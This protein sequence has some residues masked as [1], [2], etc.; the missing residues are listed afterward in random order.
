MPAPNKD[1]RWRQPTPMMQLVALIGS[2]EGHKSNHEEGIVTDTQYI[3]Y[4]D[5]HIG[6]LF[7]LRP[8]V[9]QGRW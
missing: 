6:Q 7:N 9:E 5:D 1:P 4:C 3:R 8:F 2:F